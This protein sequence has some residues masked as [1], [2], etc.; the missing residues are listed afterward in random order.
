VSGSDPVPAGF[1]TLYDAFVR[2]ECERYEGD[3]PWAI[4]KP[5]DEQD[6]LRLEQFLK[7][8]SIGS[9]FQRAQ[10]EL[11]VPF[12]KG[13]LRASVWFPP[14]SANVILDEWPETV[15]SVVPFLRTGISV[16]AG[17]IWEKF[18]GRLLFVE[19]VAFEEWLGSH[20]CRIFKGGLSSQYSMLAVHLRT[21]VKLLKQV[22]IGAITP[23]EGD[24]F[25]KA[26]GSRPL[27]RQADPAAVH[28][29]AYWSLPM[30]LVWISDRDDG[31]VIEQCDELRSSY[32]AWHEVKQRAEGQTKK[33]ELQGNPPATI[34]KLVRRGTATADVLTRRREARRELWDALQQEKLTAVGTDKSSAKR[35]QIPGF[36]WANLDCSGQED[37]PIYRSK[38]S[39]EEFADVIVPS[40]AVK[41]LWPEQKKRDLRIADARPVQDSSHRSNTGSFRR[42]AS[43]PSAG[44]RGYNKWKWQEIEQ[45]I[46]RI[47]EHHGAVDPSIEPQF[48]KAEIVRQIDAWCRKKWD[49]APSKSQFYKR[50]KKL[51]TD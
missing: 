11:L 50:L 46:R 18:N 14:F 49:G 17:H 5:P 20:V 33:W 43:A 44:T 13:Q 40:S 51:L 47:I 6:R 42:A 30:A 22:E 36:L 37:P 10:S 34:T 2:F 21:Y 12:I 7:T 32:P 39:D 23:E 45:E 4:S 9:Y 28:R 1:V 25:A 15:S 41:E 3:P 31:A 24:E 38:N 27:T 26:T 48:T 8:G 19:K 16:V 35:I 29:R